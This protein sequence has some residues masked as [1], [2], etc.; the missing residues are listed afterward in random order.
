MSRAGH[1]SE[2]S[3][4]MRVE[5]GELTC[6]GRRSFGMRRRSRRST[7]FGLAVQP[8]PFP[9]EPHPQKAADGCQLIPNRGRV[10]VDVVPLHV[11]DRVSTLEGFAIQRCAR[12]GEAGLGVT[13]DRLL[14]STIEFVAL[15]WRWR[16][17][18]RQ[19]RAPFIGRVLG[20][21]GGEP[22][23]S[24]ST[25][26]LRGARD[27]AVVAVLL[28]REPRTKAR[29]IVGLCAATG[30]FCAKQRSTVKL[31]GYGEMQGVSDETRD[32]RL[33][34]MR[35]RSHSGPDASPSSGAG[36]GY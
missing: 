4:R 29:G 20:R 34:Q 32:G 17:Q 12:A 11:R 18:W 7:L 10:A 36:D 15:R 27:E 25:I 28:L 30:S 23:A 35:Q 24:D 1:Q 16:R 3:T 2:R 31:A 9:L 22:E 14:I 6:S 33:E 26:C 21:R 19:D 8:S 13:S 5:A